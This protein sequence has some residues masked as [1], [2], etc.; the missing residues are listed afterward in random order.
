MNLEGQGQGDG[1]GLI[2]DHVRRR[3]WH[4]SGVVKL[5]ILEEGNVV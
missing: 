3:N 5:R 2:S 1:G 4:S